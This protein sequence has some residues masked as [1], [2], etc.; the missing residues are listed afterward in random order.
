MENWGTMGN[1]KRCFDKDLK[2]Y[3]IEIENPGE[4]IFIPKNDKKVLG[5]VQHFLF[6]QCKISS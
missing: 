3:I 6:L 2:S 4:K 5:I 1:V